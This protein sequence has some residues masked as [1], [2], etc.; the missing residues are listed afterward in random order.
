[1]SEIGY[2]P[3]KVKKWENLE[4]HVPNG[5]G[6]IPYGL[7]EMPNTYGVMIV[8]KTAEAAQEAFPDA[9]I[10]AVTVSAAEEEAP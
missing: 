6:P 1:M 5:G 3:M 9:E 8:Y 2:L 4:L 7:G 10:V